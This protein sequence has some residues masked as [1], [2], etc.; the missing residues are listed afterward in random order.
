[1]CVLSCKMSPVNSKSEPTA[2]S[3]AGDFDRL[4]FEQLLERLDELTQQME[5]RDVGIEAA[6][7]LYEQAAALHAAASLRLNNISKRI[8][9]LTPIDEQ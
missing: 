1:M 5:S 9:A 6:V 3:G 8:D 4:T 7:D 2:G